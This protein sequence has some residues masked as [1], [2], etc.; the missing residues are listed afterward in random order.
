MTLFKPAVDA[1]KPLLVRIHSSCA[2]GDIFHSAQCDCHDQ[3]HYSLQKISEEGGL[4]IYLDQEG[5]GI[6][7]LNKIKAY[8]LQKRGFDT[9]EAN[10]QL[11][12]PV[13]Q[14]QYYIPAALLRELAVPA[15]R[16]LTNNPQKISGLA[17]FGYTAVTREAMPSFS[18]PCNR[19]YLITKKQKLAHAICL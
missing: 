16:L 1:H 12:L 8:A 14:R 7:L 9:V 3:L 17:E 19:N 6:G 10:E 13:D 2:T 15:I 4:L 11:G 18:Q 5:R